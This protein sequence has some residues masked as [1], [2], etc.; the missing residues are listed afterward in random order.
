MENV[1]F[2]TNDYY[3]IHYKFSYELIEL[4]GRRP[5]RASGMS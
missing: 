1:H 3:F 2:A 4:R 5:Y